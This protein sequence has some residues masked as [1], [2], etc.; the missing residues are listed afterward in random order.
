MGARVSFVVIDLPA[1]PDGEKWCQAC[2]MFLKQAVN[3]ENR[4]AITGALADGKAGTVV[5]R[6]K[7]RPGHL[8]AATV[9]GI[10]AELQPF[11]M[12][13]L[14]WYHLGGVALQAPGLQGSGPLPG[15]IKGH[16]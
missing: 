7:Y 5:I 12:L 6:P 11:G 8:Q 10:C 15:L 9:T 14:C 4:E 3:A 1:P 13:E 16:G 2:A